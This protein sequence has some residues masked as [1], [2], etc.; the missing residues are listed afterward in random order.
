MQSA[1]D[2][3]R[4]QGFSLIEVLIALVIMAF[5]LLAVAQL[6]IA[7]AGADCLARSKDAATTLAVDK[8]EFLSD[9]YRRN[10]NSNE[11]T[12]GSHGPEQA[13][14]LNPANGS[15]LNSYHIKWVVE[16][17]ADPRPNQSLEIKKI[18]TGKILDSPSQFRS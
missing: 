11:L 2:N 6:M 14:I 5:G 8:L 15:T 10:P 1:L 3:T 16:N 18:S 4:N 7:S 17:V 13:Q 9:L 12:P